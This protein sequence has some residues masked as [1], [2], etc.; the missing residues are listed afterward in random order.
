MLLKTAIFGVAALAATS[1]AFLTGGR[2]GYQY[3]VH[4]IRQAASRTTVALSYPNKTPMA[5]YRNGVCVPYP[6][7]QQI[8][9]VYSVEWVSPQWEPCSGG[10]K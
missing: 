10:A 5:L 3:A 2:Y 1:G 4:E 7:P 8:P 6:D 9:T